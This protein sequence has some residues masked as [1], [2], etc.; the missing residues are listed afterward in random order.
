MRSRR[1]GVNVR[2]R[3]SIYYRSLEREM[4][5]RVIANHLQS[6]LTNDLDIALQPEPLP[7]DGNRRLL[8]V[9]VTIPMDLLTLLPDGNGNVT[10]GLSV[11]TCSGDG[12]GATSQVNVQS[13]ALRLTA[14]QWAQMKGQRIWFVLQVPLEKDRHQVSVGVV[15]HVSHN[16][17]FATLKAAP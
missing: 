2:A 17:G 11:F 13:K 3:T 7:P 12:E 14:E 8:P 6:E 15:D 10:G 16:Q 4:V 9:R 5:D 1:R